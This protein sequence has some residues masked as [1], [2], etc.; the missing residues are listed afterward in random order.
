MILTVEIP[1]SGSPR[2]WFAFD[3]NDFIRKVQLALPTTDAVVFGTTTPRELLASEGL[4]PDS[5]R[6]RITHASILALADEHGWDTILYRADML[7]APGLYQ[8]EPVDE[9]VAHVAALAHTLKSCRVYGDE[10]Q[11]LDALYSDALYAGRDG[12]Y[13]HMALR[14]QLIALEVLADDM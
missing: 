4:V 8:S 9:F 12:F 14:E 3:E 11:A 10:T 2:S 7:L 13:A 6:L 5:P 1:H